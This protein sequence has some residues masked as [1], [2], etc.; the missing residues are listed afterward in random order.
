MSFI[1][2]YATL[3]GSQDDRALQQSFAAPIADPAWFLARQWQMGEHQ[4]ENASTPV[5]MTCALRQARIDPSPDDPNRDPTIVPAE[6]IVEAEQHDWWT[7]GRRI[8]A[9]REVFSRRGPQ[10]K[11]FQFTNPPPPYERFD[12]ELDGLMLWQ[13]RDEIPGLTEADFGGVLPPDARSSGWDSSRLNYSRTFPAAATT[14]QV[15]EHTGGDV[16]WYS[17]DAAEEP[18]DFAPAEPR[19]LLPTPLEYPGAPANRFWQIEDGKVDIGGYPPDIGHFPT[20]LLVDLIYSHSDDWFLLPL[21][22]QAGFV[23]EV[24]VESV[25]DSFD[26]KWSGA[27]SVGLRPPLDWHLF[28]GRGMKASQVLSFNIA[29][30]PL[31]S[32]AIE[33]VLFGVDEASNLIWAV[34][35][36]LDGRDADSIPGA[37]PPQAVTKSGNQLKPRNWRYLPGDPPLRH[38]HPYLPSTEDEMFIQHGLADLSGTEAVRMPRPAAEVLKTESPDRPRL[39]S[40]AGSAM[41]ENG[42]SVERR[43]KLARDLAGRPQLWIQRQRLPTHAPPARRLRFDIALETV[44][45]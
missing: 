18:S 21:T 5:T 37:Q 41:P 8:R 14:L 38:W 35:R 4:G 39:H 45:P 26:L 43:W 29:E 25:R 16:D 31:E 13:R 27:D 19:E 23:T 42:I 12:G 33:R 15:V 24:E 30:T 10:S 32:A 22:L 44:S 2:A 6:V 7:M 11:R 40:L 34:E 20:M 9:G 28:R 17:V 36:I 1:D 3:H